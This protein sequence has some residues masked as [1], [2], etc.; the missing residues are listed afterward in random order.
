MKKTAA[1]FLVIFMLFQTK[2]MASWAYPFVVYNNSI[3]VVTTEPVSP[4]LLGERIGK[5]TRYS[6]REGTYRGNFSNSYPK[7]TAYYEI[8]G[9]S[10]KQQIAVQAEE[11]L[12]L[13][14][15]YQGT[16]AAAEASNNMYVWI[17]MVGAVVL[18]LVVFVFY[19]RRHRR[20]SK[21]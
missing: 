8:H 5:V 3:Y 7:G 10:P 21:V 12:Y 15:V 1:L 19:H 9:M 16:Y 4:D 11:E 13:K 6:D 17:S 18:A 2:A 14:A 20:R